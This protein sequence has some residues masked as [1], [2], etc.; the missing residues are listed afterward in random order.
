MCLV[1]R[2]KIL[3]LLTYVLTLVWQCR[4]NQ[5]TTGMAGFAA[6]LARRAVCWGSCT[7]TFLPAAQVALHRC[8]P[9]NYQTVFTLQQGSSLTQSFHL[10]RPCAWAPAWLQQSQRGYGYD[11]NSRTKPHVN[12]GTIGHVDHGKTTLTAAITKV[13]QQSEAHFKG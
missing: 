12:V 1:V 3:N 11:I 7:G 2:K 13:I 9:P 6:L 10:R 5:C 4:G 8:T